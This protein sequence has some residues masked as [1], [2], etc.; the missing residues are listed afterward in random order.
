DAAAP[1]VRELATLAEEAQRLR[2]EREEVLTQ[3]AT[4]RAAQEQLEGLT[5]WCQRVAKNLG[6]LTYADRRA[7]I[8]ALSVQAHVYRQGGPD[9]YV[10][11][12]RI[13][14]GDVTVSSTTTD[15]RASSDRTR[16]RPSA[17]TCS[18]SA[19]R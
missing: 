15:G 6:T 2:A 11:T 16:S 17:A 9:R 8:E 3:Q 5:A 10:I 13:P 18:S 1:I 12:A 7:A 4:W 19:R 14:F